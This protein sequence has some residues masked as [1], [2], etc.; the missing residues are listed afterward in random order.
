M[1]YEIGLCY[2]PTTIVF[3]DDNKNFITSIRLEINNIFNCEYFSDSLEALHFFKEEYK[4]SPFTD[5]CFIESENER[6]DNIFYHI[7][8]RKIRKE[9]QIKDRFKEVSVAVIDYN[10]P[11]MNGLELI[12]KLRAINSSIR[13]IL[14]TGE[15]DNDIAIK[16]FNDGVIDKF[17]KKG[18]TDL[19][20]VLTSKITESEHNYFAKLSQT[21]FD[22][23]NNVS[24]KLARLRDPVFVEFFNKLCKEKSFIEYYLLDD[25]GS[26]LLID[27]NGSPYWLAVLDEEELYDFYIY[28]ETEQA[29]ASVVEPLKNKEKIP[30]FYT[31]EDL[32]VFPSNWTKYLHPSQKLEGIKTYYYS[33]VNDTAIYQLNNKAI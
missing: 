24:H 5:R 1:N 33:L 28:A 11:R 13:I 17:I 18:T 7:N 8:L 3:V 14:L 21:V 2:H 23:I 4:S 20:K 22:N 6:S 16:L 27:K 9:S 26:F 32:K 10:M 30:L 29:P 31:E 12:L 15:A 19:I 25:S